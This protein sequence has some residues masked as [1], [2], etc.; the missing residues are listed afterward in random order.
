VA[1]DLVAQQQHPVAALAAERQRQQPGHVGREPAEVGPQAVQ[2]LDGGHGTG[3]GSCQCGQDLSGLRFRGRAPPA[4]DLTFD[5]RHDARESHHAAD[6]HA[7]RVVASRVV[8]GIDQGI[9]AVRRQQQAV[10]VALERLPI[11]PRQRQAEQ[12]P[13][14]LG[15][16][17]ACQRRAHW[18]AVVA[19]D[20]PP[21]GAIDDQRD[22]HRSR[23]AH[24]AQVLQMHRRDAAQR[25]QREVQRG[26]AARQHRYAVVVGIRNDPG[27]IAQ[28][29]RP[30]LRR[31]V[32]GRI[33]QPE[34]R[35]LSPR[36]VL[37]N[38][39]A[40]AVRR[41]AVDHHPV[42]ARQAGD[43]GGRRARQSV[44]IVVA[45]E[46]ARAA[47]DRERRP[48]RRSARGFGLDDNEPSAGV[49]A[50]V[51]AAGASGP[52]DVVKV[53]RLPRG[54]RHLGVRDGSGDSARRKH[55]IGPR[56]QQRE[57]FAPAPV[58]RGV[59]GRDDAPPVVERDQDAERLDTSE[60]VDGFARALRKRGVGGHGLHHVATMAAVSPTRLDKRQDGAP[61]LRCRRPSVVR[62]RHSLESRQ[63]S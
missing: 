18:P 22:R 25:G 26:A 19:G 59:R 20:Q 8:P 33:A 30:R 1:F 35:R 44:D 4:S 31:D 40:A 38:H 17:P 10:D 21:E 56:I 37:G 63:V 45:G 3:G 42:V 61:L 57:G 41:E 62:L 6:R 11:G 12:T 43:G 29:Q 2:G 51:G 13:E 39:G 50:H 9:D 27:R 28:V 54:G 47:L 16:R 46:I 60:Q 14:Q 23:G 5:L 48:R 32:A 55:R 24:V 7:G 53:L 49:H 34:I 36:P 15:H 58:P 52:G